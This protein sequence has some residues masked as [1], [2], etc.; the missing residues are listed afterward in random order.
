MQALNVTLQMLPESFDWDATRAEGYLDLYENNKWIEGLEAVFQPAKG[1]VEVQG[2]GGFMR[3]F[4]VAF[5]EK[6]LGTKLEGL[7]TDKAAG[8]YFTFLESIGAVHAF[9]L[10]GPAGS[11]L[12]RAPTQEEA[13]VFITSIDGWLKKAFS[14]SVLVEKEEALKE[15][16]PLNRDQFMMQV[17]HY[18]QLRENL[19]KGGVGNLMY[20]DTPLTSA[21]KDKS[22]VLKLC[23]ERSEND[24][25]NW[26]EYYFV[27]F[28]G[29]LYFYKDSRDPE[30]AGIVA[31]KYASVELDVDAVKEKNHYNFKITTPMRTVT[32][33]AKHDVA[34]SEWVV[35]LERAL[36]KH[37]AKGGMAVRSTNEVLAT[38]HEITGVKA[39]ERNVT[40]FHEKMFIYLEIK[41]PEKKRPWTVNLPKSKDGSIKSMTI[42][43][44][45]SNGIIIDDE[46]MSRA[47]AKVEYTDV[48]LWLID[49]GSS[50][51]CKLNGAEKRFTRERLDEGDKVKLGNSFIA[52]GL[53]Q[54]GKYAK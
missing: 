3:S 36:A 19:A 20:E 52:V 29:S 23:L 50:S 42:G 30:P 14:S 51:G 12:F 26:V 13:S 33:R 49:V 7:G 9:K 17:A 5:M 22:G 27:L 48:A 25:S 6:G 46:R 11:L 45:Q 34:L 2:T 24:K 4:R 53:K 31:L 47:H 16:T 54:K 37:L 15:L 35:G 40:D 39:Q 21:A 32:L 44:D 8:M 28:N 1:I 10:F 18:N 43:R 41:S 38:L